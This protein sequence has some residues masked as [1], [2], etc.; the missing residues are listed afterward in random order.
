M[1]TPRQP[2]AVSIESLALGTS[3][4]RWRLASPS[5]SSTPAP[6][7]AQRPRPGNPAST[8]VPAAASGP[9]R[10]RPPLVYQGIMTV[11]LP[12][13]EMLRCTYP[14]CAGCQ[15]RTSVSLLLSAG[16]PTWSESMGFGQRGVSSGASPVMPG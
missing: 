6:P 1:P 3:R 5:G 13:P 14:G 2:P 8:G 4:R 9:S 12:V 10:F 16:G 7:P 11:Y 15:A